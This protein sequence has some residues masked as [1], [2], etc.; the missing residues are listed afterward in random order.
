MVLEIRRLFILTALTAAMLLPTPAGASVVIAP[1]SGS[2]AATL[3]GN[4]LTGI[5]STDMRASAALAVI[6]SIGPALDGIELATDLSSPAPNPGILVT[7]P[8]TNQTDLLLFDT[9]NADVSSGLLGSG[10]Q[11]LNLIAVGAPAGTVTDPGLLDLVGPNDFKFVLNQ[12]ASSI[13]GQTGDFRLV[14]TLVAGV[15]AGVTAVP[16]P[17]SLGVVGLGIVLCGCAVKP[18]LESARVQ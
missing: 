17:I 9:A 4:L 7:S 18:S 13:N 1:L 14:Y 11:V 6:N 15:G 10:G 12:G 3:D 2:F 8:I 16:E 5:A